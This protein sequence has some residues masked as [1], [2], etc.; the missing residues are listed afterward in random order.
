M[1]PFFSPALPGLTAA[2]TDETKS[3]EVPL[4]NA[5]QVGGTLRWSSGCSA[6]KVVFEIAPVTGYAGKWEAI[7][8][9]DFVA[10]SQ[11]ADSAVSFT[12]PGPFSGFGRWRIDTTITGGTVTTDTQIFV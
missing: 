12:Y 3:A 6:G 9:S 5:Q 11:V 7:F 8:S 1:I 10:D 2:A 4:N